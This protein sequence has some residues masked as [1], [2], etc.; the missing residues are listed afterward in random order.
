ML[1]ITPL[2]NDEPWE[3]EGQCYQECRGRNARCL[4]TPRHN[5]SHESYA[6]RTNSYNVVGNVLMVTWEDG[7]VPYT[8]IA[9]KTVITMLRLRR[10]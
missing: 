5:G 6:V 9:D 4:L 10:C 7:Q 1:D 3:Y 2:D 8:Y